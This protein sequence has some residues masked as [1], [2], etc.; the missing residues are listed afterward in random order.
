[1]D[2]KLLFTKI[3]GISLPWF[4]KQVD[5]AHL[6]KEII[7]PA[8]RD[9]QQVST[10]F[11]YYRN[12]KAFNYANQKNETETLDY[13]LYRRRT[14]VTDP[15]GFI[16]EYE[17]DPDNGALTKL[18][19]PDGAILRFDNNA[20]GLRF[21]KTDALNFTTTYSYRSDR[22]LSGGASD[23]GGNVSLERD[24]LNYD[25]HYDY[26]LFD[27]I[28]RVRDK[29]GNERFYTYYQTTVPGTGAVRG[30]L[31][32]VEAMLG[33]VR[34]T[35]ETYT[36]YDNGN[37][38]QKIEHIDPADPTRRR[39]TDYTWDAAGL[40][41]LQT[42]TAGATSGGTVTVDYTYDTLGR[43]QTETLYRRT[44]ADDPTLM[45][46]TT[47]YEYDTLGRVIRVTDPLGSIQET[48]Y[49][50][51]GKVYQTKIH[52]KQPG[53]S[54]DVRT[55][56][57]RTYDAADRLVSETDIYDNTTTYEYDAAGNLIQSTDA[58]GHI[59]QYEYDAMGRR[60]AVIDANGHRTE[61]V[62]DLAGRVV[63]TIDANGNTMKFEYDAMGRKTKC[64]LPHYSD[65][66]FFAILTIFKKFRIKPTSFDCFYLRQ[67]FYRICRIRLLCG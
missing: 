24:P 31:E 48:V 52:H 62:F 22:T 57:T 60:T 58:N 36:Y 26:G 28:T 49:D 33:G 30:R 37:V 14:R 41:L 56:V 34:T 29:N 55:Y 59:T 21:Q 10:T 5:D 9:G 23:T 2:D 20:D 15:R 1:M 18:T 40:N 35:L 32:K 65:R 43:K 39:I 8:D 45:A 11:A 42:V 27:Q 19:E 25:V 50:A 46:L 47:T 64:W 54:F 6:L 17:Y 44:S 16:R 3:L 66:D 12:H 7:L 38:Q 63:Q 13:D 61:T 67:G 53:G 51:N 4:V